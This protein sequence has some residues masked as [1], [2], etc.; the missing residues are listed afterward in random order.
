MNR[1]YQRVSAI[2]RALPGWAN[3][4]ADTII[5]LHWL[6]ARG[7]DFRAI[8]PYFLGLEAMEL[9]SPETANHPVRADDS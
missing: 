1:S 5:T 4:I 8:I 9:A 6:P 3:S 7:I 2:S